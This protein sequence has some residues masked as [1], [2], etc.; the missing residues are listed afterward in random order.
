M[1]DVLILAALEGGIMGLN[2]VSLISFSSYARYL[3][4][5]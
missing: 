4:N 3:L 2:S 5:C 1:E